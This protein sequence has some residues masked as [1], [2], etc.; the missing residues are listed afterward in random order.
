[1]FKT[2]NSKRTLRIDYRKC[3]II[4]NINFLFSFSFY[5][6]LR[7]IAVLL[8]I[9][10]Q[11][12]EMTNI[13][14]GEK[15][16]LNKDSKDTR[17][18][19]NDAL[20]NAGCG[21]GTLLYTSGTF[22]FCCLLGSEVAMFA[23]VGPVL[24]CEWNL[25]SFSLASLQMSNNIAMSFS[26]GLTSP[27]G[28]RYGRRPM[29]LIGAVGVTITGVL[30]AFTKNYWQMLVLRLVM[31]V[32]FGLGI[33]PANVFSGELV[34]KKYRALALSGNSLAWGIAVLINSAITV[35]VMDPYGWQGVLLSIPIAF[36]SAC[37]IPL[38][39]IRGSP[40]FDYYS[41]NVER[42]ERTIEKL[43]IL[44][45]K[46][47][48]TIKLKDVDISNSEQDAG[49]CTTYK[50][51]KRTDNL[52]NTFLIMLLAIFVVSIY[53][54]YAYII[55][56]LLNEGYCSG[57]SIDII[58]SCSF[59]KKTLLELT[60]TYISEPVGLIIT[61]PLLEMFGRKKVF[62]AAAIMAFLLPT[63]L[64]FC[65]RQ[66]YLLTF[67]IFSFASASSLT[68]APWLLVVEY[69]PT[70]IRSYMTSVMAVFA[71][72]ASSLA[73][74]AAEYIFSYSPSVAIG[75]IQITVLV[76]VI[77][78]AMLKRETGGANLM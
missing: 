52:K 73:I 15:S 74:F 71:Y 75:A 32:F 39:S 42:A 47:K 11:V 7:I 23:I 60:I 20:E 55:P 27:L 14:V 37:I 70:V 48:V 69:M 35:Y 12:K 4:I 67:L 25:D 33:P 19:I 56:Q 40:R 26:T 5:I 63:S 53:H 54:L 6:F 44:N 57:H 21:L 28:D 78:F 64:Y 1:M 2:T 77:C 50:I 68:L 8:N 49:L 16:L 46:G 59:D 66:E 9:L 65:V 30:C 38:A 3:N 36:S 45:G 34:P 13:E 58:D 10:F 62:M 17:V 22:F 29:A 51:L 43:Y 18:D 31:G 61:L 76:A 72:F 41:G 24:K